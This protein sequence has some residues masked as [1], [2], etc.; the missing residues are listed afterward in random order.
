MLPHMFLVMCM[1]YIR[2]ERK[3]HSSVAHS[4]QL[5][6]GLAQLTYIFERA[7]LAF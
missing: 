7:N 4:T 2:A 3:A 5:I 6:S 1:G